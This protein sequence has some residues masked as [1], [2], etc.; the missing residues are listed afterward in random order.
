MSNRIIFARGGEKI[1]DVL[2]PEGKI[3]IGTV[4]SVTI[5]GIF[6]K[7]GIPVTSRFGG[8]VETENGKPTRFI[9]LISYEGSSLDPAG[10]IHKKQDDRCHWSGEKS[11]W[12]DTCKF[13]R[14]S[15]CL[16]C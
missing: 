1:G 14:D 10:D 15:C 6:L 4:C 3:G 7:A 16:S 11:S 12:E 8:V 9:S 5:N 13:Q 2:I